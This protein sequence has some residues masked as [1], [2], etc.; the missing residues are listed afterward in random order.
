[1]TDHDIAELTTKAAEI[2][3]A[4]AR[5]DATFRQ[6]TNDLQSFRN[7]IRELVEQRDKLLRDLFDRDV[8]VAADAD[9]IATLTS[10]IAELAKVMDA[11]A[12]E[13]GAM[14][15]EIERLMRKLEQQQ[16]DHDKAI[17]ENARTLEQ[18]RQAIAEL[19]GRGLAVSLPLL[20]DGGMGGIGGAGGLIVGETL[21]VLG[22]GGGGGASA[23]TA[24]IHGGSG[25]GRDAIVLH[26]GDNARMY[27]SADLD[28]PP[29][30]VATSESLAAQATAMRADADAWAAGIV[31]ALQI[32]SGV[33]LDIACDKIA[34]TLHKA[35]GRIRV[36][37]SRG[38][39]TLETDTDLR[40]RAIDKVREIAAVPTSDLYRI[41]DSTIASMTPDARVLAAWARSVVA[42]RAPAVQWHELRDLLREAESQ[43]PD[44]PDG[45]DLLQVLSRLVDQRSDEGPGE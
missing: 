9:T 12:V 38:R 35:F 42:A 18:A 43:L 14:R 19:R 5:V 6:H 10:E 28:L 7:T 23:N 25:P 13:H 40:R 32:V 17:G 24:Q 4:I 33:D 16:A 26:G 45:D 15:E 20:G 30:P 1:M 44:C 29:P 37:G 41:H 3:Q 36:D 2:V 8:K 27:T 31:Q 21:Q 34:S 39:S 11:R 22:K